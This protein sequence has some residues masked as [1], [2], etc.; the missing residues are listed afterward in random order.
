VIG[1]LT[2]L[3]QTTPTAGHTRAANKPARMRTRTCVCCKSKSPPVT[4][5]RSMCCARFKAKTRAIRM[6]TSFAT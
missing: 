4:I 3:R 1:A 2:L 6:R 5:W